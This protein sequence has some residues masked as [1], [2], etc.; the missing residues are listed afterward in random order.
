MLRKTIEF[1]FKEFYEHQQRRIGQE[2]RSFKI[3]KQAFQNG[4]EK[5][6]RKRFLSLMKMDLIC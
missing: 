6:L 5:D 4:V 3:I 1:V 2:C